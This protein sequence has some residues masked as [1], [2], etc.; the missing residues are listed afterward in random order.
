MSLSEVR[1]SGAVTEGT[2]IQVLT[3]RGEGAVAYS[4]VGQKEVMALLRPFSAP[5]QCARDSGLFGPRQRK[6]AR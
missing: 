2:R 3:N 5:T 6:E 4:A 1:G